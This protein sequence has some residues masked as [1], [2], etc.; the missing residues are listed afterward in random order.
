M[1]VPRF[2]HQWSNLH[3]R[4]RR[5]PLQS[6]HRQRKLLFDLNWVF[7]ESLRGCPR[8]RVIMTADHLI[9]LS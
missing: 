6:L 5:L 3:R 9:F 7:C 8:T 1:N 4:H 2:G